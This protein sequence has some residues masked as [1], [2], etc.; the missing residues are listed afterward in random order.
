MGLGLEANHSRSLLH[1]FQGVFDLMKPALRREDGIVGVVGIAELQLL[2]ISRL[3]HRTIGYI[4]MLD[5]R[6]ERATR[7]SRR[8]VG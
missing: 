7:L 4:T 3:V 8:N 5:W 6:S 1:G 2:L